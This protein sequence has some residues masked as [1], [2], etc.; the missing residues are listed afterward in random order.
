MKNVLVVGGSSGIGSKLCEI[1][2]ADGH[3]VHATFLNTPVASDNIVY[4]QLDVRDP[5]IDLSF[6]PETLHGL[7]FCPGSISLRPFSRISSDDF[8]SDF[9]L[10]VGGFVRTLQA[11]LPKLKAGGSGSVVT[12][13]S[14]AASQ[15]MSFH[16]QVSAT[17]SALE[18]VT[19][20]LAAELAPNIRVNCIAPSLTDTPLAGALLS[21]PEKR[22]ANAQRHPLKRIG[23]ASDIAHMAAFLLSDSA[24]WI[25]GQII[26]VDGGLSSL[27]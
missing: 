17:K 20:A 15:G 9:N 14:V 23:E 11:A 1:L 4:R 6:L 18:G 10:Q 22:E 16:A 13:S 27:R 12:F 8:V 7:V 19:R 21:S 24:R 5:V 3:A 25:T 26:G 2:S